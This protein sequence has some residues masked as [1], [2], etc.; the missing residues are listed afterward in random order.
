LLDVIA[1]G[2]AVAKEAP[3]SPLPAPASAATRALAKRLA[4]ALQDLA[5]GLSMNVEILMPNREL[6][7]LAREATGETIEIPPAWLGWR[8]EAVIRPMRDIAGQIGASPC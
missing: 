4:P 2:R 7:L 1:Q 8:A 3:P 6:E 5:L